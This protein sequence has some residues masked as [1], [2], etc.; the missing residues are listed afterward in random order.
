MGA[1]YCKSMQ[2]KVLLLNRARPFL[3]PAKHGRSDKLRLCVRRVGLSKRT[4]PITETISRKTDYIPNLEIFFSQTHI[5]KTYKLKTNL[6]SNREI[7]DRSILV[8]C[9]FNIDF[10]YHYCFFLFLNC[11]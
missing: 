3:S 7:F 8:T 10:S 6:Y 11:F 9:V 5:S 2:R 1:L 4:R